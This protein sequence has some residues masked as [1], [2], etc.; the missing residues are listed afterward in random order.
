MIFVF[1]TQAGIASYWGIL[2]AYLPSFCYE[3]STLTSIQFAQLI[4]VMAICIPIG[5]LMGGLIADWIGIKKAYLIYSII[6]LIIIMPVFH[7]IM[8]D[9]VPMINVLVVMGG[10]ALLTVLLI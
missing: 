10:F 7:Y 2:V 4:L 8:N 5:N 3:Y 6:M 1:F 9:A